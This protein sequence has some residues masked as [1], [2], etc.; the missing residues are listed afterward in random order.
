MI[1]LAYIYYLISGIRDDLPFDTLY[2]VTVNQMKMMYFNFRGFSR[3]IIVRHK[4]TSTWR[5]EM[6]GESNKYAV[7]NSTE[8]PFGMQKYALSEVRTLEVVK[9]SS[10]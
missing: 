3:S 5:M 8:P 1:L 4:N 2:T 10:T 9:S 6:L 7:T